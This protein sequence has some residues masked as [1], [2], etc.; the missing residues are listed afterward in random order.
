[1]TLPPVAQFNRDIAER[2][3]A[4]AADDITV[5]ISELRAHGDIGRACETAGIELARFLAWRNKRPELSVRVRDAIA[6][7]KSGELSYAAWEAGR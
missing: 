4:D 5:A 6:F 7:A 1:M 3:Y 2:N